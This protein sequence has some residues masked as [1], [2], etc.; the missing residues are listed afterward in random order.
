[1]GIKNILFILFFIT[2]FSLKAENDSLPWITLNIKTGLPLFLYPNTEN[3]PN[4]SV[5]QSILQNRS[6]MIDFGFRLNKKS[7]LFLGGQILGRSY[8]IVSHNTGYGFVSKNHGTSI[9]SL[10][11]TYSYLFYNKNNLKCFIIPRLW[12]SHIAEDIQYKYNDS[13]PPN[14]YTIRGRMVNPTVTSTISPSFG[15][16]L[17]RKLFIKELYFMFQT[18]YVFSPYGHRTSRLCLNTGLSF[19]IY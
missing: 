13:I 19:K 15:F 4:A 12:F 1:M 6:Y 18:E 2:F 10:A 17:E 5:S 14:N 7:Q 9:L 11:L 16:G 8:E 3:I